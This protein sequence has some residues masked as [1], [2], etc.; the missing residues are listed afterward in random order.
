MRSFFSKA[1]S[2]EVAPTKP[3]QADAC[4]PGEAEIA[5]VCSVAVQSG[6]EVDEK[7][8]ERKM[9][10]WSVFVEEKYAEIRAHMPADQR[11]AACVTKQA[12]LE[13]WALEDAEK[14]YYYKAA[15]DKTTLVGV[16]FR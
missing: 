16:T 11:S 4:R 2:V 6:V 3:V 12:S 15:A 8:T 10:G 13:W 7:S 9:T 1:K 5:L 14:E